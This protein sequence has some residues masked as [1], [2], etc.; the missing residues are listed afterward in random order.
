[1]K[2][3]F[4][5]LF[6]IIF[7]CTTKEGIPSVKIDCP[8]E[9]DHSIEFKESSIERLYFFGNHDSL[10]YQFDEDEPVET[11]TN[12][13]VERIWTM[14]KWECPNNEVKIGG[15]ATKT[16]YATVNFELVDNENISMI[17]VKLR[18]KFNERDLSVYS[19]VVEVYYW[20]GDQRTFTGFRYVVDQRTDLEQN[21]DDLFYYKFKTL[22]GVEYSEVYSHESDEFLVDFN[23]K[24][25]VLQIFDKY[26]D[27]YFVLE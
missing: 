21:N 14:V 19:D 7:F 20:V 24:Y 27:E 8:A 23:E 16:D 3:I 18:A 17:T 4:L 1:M 11:N 15:S 25:G 22:S 13:L 2:V 5:A 9:I 10:F 12:S 6:G 26:N